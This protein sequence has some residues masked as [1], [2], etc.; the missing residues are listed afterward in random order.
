MKGVGFQPNRKGHFEDGEYRFKS[1][2]HCVLRVFVR[3]ERV[4]GVR[5]VPALP[6]GGEE[7][8][9]DILYITPEERAHPYVGLALGDAM[10]K[11]LEEYPAPTSYSQV[12][13]G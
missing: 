11:H 10:A 9:E 2:T 7:P 13:V 4:E 5:A 6:E 12:T 8:L 1:G 3:D